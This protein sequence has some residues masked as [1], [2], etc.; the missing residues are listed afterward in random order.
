M[1]NLMNLEDNKISTQLVGYP[2]VFTG[3]TGD[4]KTDSLNRYLKSVSEDG[5]EPLFFMFEDRYKAIKGIKAVRITKISE[6]KQYVNQLNNPQLKEKFSCIVFDTADKFEELVNKYVSTNKDVEILEDIGYS[7][8]KKYLKSVVSII[9]EI[10]NMGYP[11]HFCVQMFKTTDFNTQQ[12]VYKWKISE[13]LKAQITQEAF[14]VGLV[15]MDNTANN[16]VTADRNITFFKTSTYP[17]LKD[18]FGLPKTMKV[19]SIKSELEKH[20]N[21]SYDKSE[22]TGDNVMEVI[23]DKD[24]FKEIIARGKAL[25]NMLF[26]NGL[27]GEAMNILSTTIGTTDK[28][29]PKTFDD[30]TEQQK[31]L[32]KVVVL[33]LEN[34]CKS[35]KISVE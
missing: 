20:F 3:E 18:S 32:A 7:K 35:H 15:T 17:D 10:R 5:K 13:E 14:L 2:V 34:L 28:G 19:G 16:K 31:D 6:L 11:V 12:T 29:E 23:E 1:I 24:D 21:N 4:G 9:S 8:G 27:I 26:Q 22:L 30:I 25:G 33:K